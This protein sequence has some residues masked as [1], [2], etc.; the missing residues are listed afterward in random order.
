MGIFN[1]LKSWFSSPDSPKSHPEA[2]PP[3]DLEVGAVLDATHNSAVQVAPYEEEAAQ[4]ENLTGAITELLNAEGK[5]DKE[6]FLAY[7]QFAYKAGKCSP[8]SRLFFLIS[9]LNKNKISREDVKS[10]ADTLVDYAAQSQLV[11]LTE[12]TDELLEAIAQKTA[13]DPNFMTTVMHKDMLKDPKVRQGAVRAIRNRSF[14]Q[15]DL[16]LLV[17]AITANDA[18]YLMQIQQG[19]STPFSKASIANSFVGIERQLKYYE[20]EQLAE[21]IATFVELES[22]LTV[23]NFYQKNLERYPIS[24]LENTYP[25]VGEPNISVSEY[26]T[27]IKN[28]IKPKLQELGYSDNEIELLLYAKKETSAEKTEHEKFLFGFRESILQK[29]RENAAKPVTEVADNTDADNE[30]LDL[31][32]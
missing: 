3:K 29:T 18:R 6:R 14:D 16:H 31:A 22:T 10:L 4:T 26:L 1:T 27:R 25:S 5:F 9:T 30:Q 17:P 23:R 8:E 7:V 2:T 28:F 21:L 19:E 24:E 15:D 11:W 12:Q 20:G 13:E 32:A